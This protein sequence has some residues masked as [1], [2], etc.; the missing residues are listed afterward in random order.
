MA[1]QRKRTAAPPSPNGDMPPAPGEITIP[2]DTLVVIRMESGEFGYA[3][4]G[5]STVPKEAWPTALRRVAALLERQIVDG[6]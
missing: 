2:D 1:S 6:G 5:P 3:I 4:N